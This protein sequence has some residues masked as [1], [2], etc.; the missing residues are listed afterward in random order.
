[1]D[2]SGTEVVSGELRGIGSARGALQVLDFGLKVEVDDLRDSPFPEPAIIEVDY[3]T[4]HDDRA[5]P[6][7]GAIRT[8][9]EPRL[10]DKTTSK[11]EYVL[12]RR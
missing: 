2:A 1:M 11:L 10:R 12:G 9:L 7:A 8:A 4:A 6:I 5:R 3:D